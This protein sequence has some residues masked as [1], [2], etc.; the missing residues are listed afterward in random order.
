MVQDLHE[1][2]ARGDV[3]MGGRPCRD[4]LPIVQARAATALA[5]LHLIQHIHVYHVV[6]LSRLLA[7]D[8][9]PDGARQVNSF[10]LQPAL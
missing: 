4:L 1:W 3:G 6:V 7:A 9:P 10:P 8:A 2:F 5:R